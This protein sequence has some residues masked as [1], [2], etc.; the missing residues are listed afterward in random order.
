MGSP[1][2]RR[3]TNCS[4]S[5]ITEHSLHGIALPP[6]ARVELTGAGFY[7]DVGEGDSIYPVT[8]RSVIRRPLS[9]TPSPATHSSRRKCYLCVRYEVL[10]MCQVGHLRLKI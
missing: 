8:K 5:S 6:R 2:S 7:R 10:P 9:P 1:D 3:A 4:L